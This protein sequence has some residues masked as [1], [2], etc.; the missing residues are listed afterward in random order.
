MN[1]NMIGLNSLIV[2]LIFIIHP[3][4]FLRNFV[5]SPRNILSLENFDRKLPEYDVTRN[6]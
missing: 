4:A 1:D 5:V 6:V 2:R 3:N